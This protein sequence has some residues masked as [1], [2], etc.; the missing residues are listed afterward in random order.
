MCLGVVDAILTAATKESACPY[1][2]PCDGWRLRRII[3]SYRAR[4]G[5]P[6]LKGRPRHLQHSNQDIGQIKDIALDPQGRAVAYVVSVGGFLGVDQQHYVAVRASAVDV[7]YN[8]S[9]KKRHAAMNATA[10]QLKAAPEF[11]YSGRWSSSQAAVGKFEMNRT[12]EPLG[13]GV[14]Q[15]AAK[16]LR[17]RR[18]SP[19]HR[20]RSIPGPVDQKQATNRDRASPWPLRTRHTSPHSLLARE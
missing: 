4:K 16:A 11:G 2:G 6:G 14:E 13:D 10:S 5:W 1:V 19:S 8:P 7:G 3:G 17:P 20:I 9:T 15:L 18:A 12:V